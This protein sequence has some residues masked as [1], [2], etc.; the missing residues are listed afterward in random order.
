LQRTDHGC[1]R[2]LWVTVKSTLWGVTTGCL[3]AEF[4]ALCVFD[5]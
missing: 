4:S 2:G 1:T 3:S 5:C